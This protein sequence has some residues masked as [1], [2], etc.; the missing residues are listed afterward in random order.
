MWPKPVEFRRVMPVSTEECVAAVDLST[1]SYYNTT[2]MNA[3]YLNTTTSTASIEL[4]PERLI[5]I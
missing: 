4:V 3:A 5:L 2:G 1:Q